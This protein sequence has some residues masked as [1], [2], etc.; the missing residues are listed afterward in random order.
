M[1]STTDLKNGVC[2]VFNHDVFQVTEFLH[3]KP[4]KGPAFVRTKLKSLTTGKVLDNTFPSGS[5]IEIVRIERRKYQYLYKDDI[6]YHFM[7]CDTYEQ[8]SLEKHLIDNPQYLSDGDFVEIMFH[9]EEERPMTCELPS[10][11]ESEVTYTEPGIKGDTATNAMKP[12]TISTGA[13][14]KVP[15]F[16][17]IGD[18]IKVDTRSGQY[19]ERLK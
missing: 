3:V 14:I 9:A 16:I 12:A 17:N 1:D 5:K 8:I 15:L 18:R 4:G 11:I 6:G 13:E 19:S 2:I 7:N 10:F